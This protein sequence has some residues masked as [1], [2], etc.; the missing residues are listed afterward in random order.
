MTFARTKIQ[1]PRLRNGALVER[2]GLEARL[3]EALLSHRLVLVCAAAGYGKTAALARQIERLPTGTAHAWIALDE[4]DDLH[5]LLGCLAAALEPY[6]PPWRVAPEALIAQATST[7]ARQR[8]TAAAELLNTLDACEVPHGVI[9]LDDLHRV[10]DEA[11]F[12]FL[13]LLIR[14]LGPRWT[15][16]VA[17]RSQPPLTL[18]RLRAAGELVHIGQ[19][20]LQMDRDEVRALAATT[21]LD[22]GE[23]D[24]L[25][26]RT[27]GWAA[28][29]RLALSAMH[30]RGSVLR[31]A[32]LDRH[33]FEFI[34]TEVL[35]GLPPPLRDFLLQ[36]SVLPELTAAR[37]AAVTGLP[38]AEAA[39]ML[40]DIERRGLFVSVL[41]A[42]APTEDDAPF[43]LKLHD[44]FRDALDHRLH[45][46]RPQDVAAL[47]ERAAATEPDATRRI[48]LLLRAGRH[49][50][51][52]QVLL[53]IG[54][55][56]LAEGAVASMARLVAQF[57][58]EWAIGSPELQRMRGLVAWA[59]WD[60]AEMLDAMRQA[61]SAYE[62]RGDVPGQQATQAYQALALNAFGRMHEAGQRLSVLRRE[63]LAPDVRIA[64]LVAC[65]WHALE[66]GALHRV[67]PVLDELMD[68]LQRD[69]RMASWYHCMPL[70]RFNGLRGTAVPLQRYAD[71]A[72]RVAGDTPT[73]L[74]ASA[75]VQH[76]WRRLWQGRLDEAED[77][78]RRG[79]ADAAWVGNPVNVRQHLQALAAVLHAVRGR[80]A[81]ALA[82]ART[83]IEEIAAHRNAWSHA[84]LLFQVA[85][86]AVLC[87]DLALLSS[88][89]RR[90]PDAPQHVPL[91]GHAARLQGRLDDAIAHW[92]QALQQEERIDLVGQAAET[93]LH[94]AQALAA[95][96]HPV[97]AAA[98]LAP[99][100]ARVDEEGEPGGVLLAGGPVAALAAV[101]WQHML[102]AARQA[103]LRTWARLLQAAAPGPEPPPQIVLPT[104]PTVPARAHPPVE[105]DGEDDGDPEAASVSA[106]PRL[107]RLSL[108]PREREVLAR[109]AN[110]DSN[111]LI[112]RAFDLSPHTVK[113][114][115][116]NLL[117][118]LGVDS[119]GQA[120]AWYRGEP[121]DPRAD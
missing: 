92:Q 85:R 61:E 34:A 101:D 33:A 45:R 58:A 24:A 10:D 68:L 57:P 4:G 12:G 121:R 51:A 110:G 104:A 26:Q 81:E 78:W 90:L 87:D 105:E 73:P 88:C 11:V 74:R 75:M 114:H 99:V 96:G 39:A 80:R 106:H 9:V 21:G 111:K 22:A 13:D 63:A 7:D 29:L 52:A 112:A 48:G 20:E 49:A 53:A 44:L 116:A 42:E 38:L 72:Q 18:A 65:S 119:R 84:Q 27:Q 6:D 40:D 91:R 59:R 15:M 16:A 103:A 86:V 62:A 97:Q 54:P 98:V 17:S 67:G 79:V 64:V 19:A 1:P 30:E 95:G 8:Q 94:L 93:R 28:G 43:T 76:G 82:I 55:G 60:F 108:S 117:D 69:S 25:H 37:T 109:I 56:E 107:A 35:D 2:R 46:E 36:T 71:G 66:V 89:L 77:A 23:A 5:R 41:D 14:R 102:P 113:R 120:A 32:T 50:E 115:V 47:L 70:P 83:R 118:K 3:G 31:R 100:F